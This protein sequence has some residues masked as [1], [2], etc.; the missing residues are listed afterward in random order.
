LPGLLGGRGEAPRPPGTQQL[1][2]EDSQ[3]L[4]KGNVEPVSATLAHP[5]SAGVSRD[6]SQK[7]WSY[8]LLSSCLSPGVLRPGADTWQKSSTEIR[9]VSEKIWRV[10][11]EIWILQ[12][13]R[14]IGGKIIRNHGGH[15]NPSKRVM[16][17]EGQAPINLITSGTQ[18][19]SVS[20]Q[21]SLP[22]FLG[23]EASTASTV[24]CLPA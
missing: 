7:F 20:L 9:A 13:S 12:G 10:E 6:L 16:W 24:P 14:A 5:Q 22:T 2:A 17:G 18:H 21:T 19:L 1:H 4:Q 8:T 15:R 3:G 11:T 23:L